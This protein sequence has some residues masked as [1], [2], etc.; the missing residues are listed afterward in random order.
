MYK[1]ILMLAFLAVTNCCKYGELYVELGK[2]VYM[3]GGVPINKVNK[4]FLSL[5]DV[6]NNLLEGIPL[7][8]PQQRSVISQ[9]RLVVY[10]EPIIDN[11]KCPPNFI[12]LDTM[13]I[14]YKSNPQPILIAKHD[15]ESIHNGC[16]LT[17]GSDFQ[18]IYYPPIL[19]RLIGRQVFVNDSPTAHG[20]LPLYTVTAH[21]YTS[22]GYGQ[23]QFI[24]GKIRLKL[25]Y[26]CMCPFYLWRQH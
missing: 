5:D 18:N 15:C 12:E 19:S 23:T 16:M 20:L 22:D 25:P 6:E 8:K 7:S 24:I 9:H 21:I 1:Y 17:V 14:T 10:S 11:R 4:T 26:V 2:C 13:C 3:Y